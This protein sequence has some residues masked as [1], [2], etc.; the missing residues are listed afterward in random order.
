MKVFDLKA[1]FAS[2]TITTSS[3]S[4]FV[5]LEETISPMKTEAVSPGFQESAPL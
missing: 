1:Q 5:S 3:Q 4:V 2:R